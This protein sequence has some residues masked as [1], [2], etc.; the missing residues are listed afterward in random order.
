MSKFDNFRYT[1]WV[2]RLNRIAQIALC[3]VLWLALN[4]IA[5]IQFLRVDISRDHKYSL[6][7]ETLKYIEKIDKPVQI[8][9]CTASEQP[10]SEVAGILEDISNLLREYEY[11]GRI[12]G[13]KKIDVQFINIYRDHSQAQ[14][15]VDK[16]RVDPTKEYAI[17]VACGDNYQEILLTELY[18]DGEASEFRGEEV[19]TS[20]ILN[21]S[22]PEKRKVY[23][24]T[25]HGEMDMNDVSPD[26]GLS[27]AAQSLRQSNLELA[28]LDLT[29]TPEVPDDADL[30]IIAA[31]KTIIVPYEVEKL[32]KYLDNGSG[33]IMAFLHPG[34]VHG[35]D[36]MFWKWGILA[37]DM[38]VVVP[39]DNLSPG[40]GIPIENFGEHPIT[41][42]HR[43]HHL[44]VLLTGNSRPVREDP[45]TAFDE[46]L[47][48]SPLLLTPKASYA[49]RNYLEQPYRIDRQ[50]DLL[51]PISVGMVAERTIDSNLGLNIPSGR[52][53]VFGNAS[54]ITNRAFN[55]SGN[56][57]LFEHAVNWVLGHNEL[58]G[59]PPRKHE[60][61]QLSLTKADLRQ[62]LLLLLA[63]PAGTIACGAII[64]LL[65][66][67]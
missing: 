51:G 2:K 59:I 46:R 9:V 60:Q 40:G 39:E 42:F 30:V 31:P 13:K 57:Y 8:Y 50:Q 29:K 48:I 52:L 64:A 4:Y 22:N 56:R 45:G 47:K 34:L 6:S 63:L 43:T 35:L 53:I 66:R 25:G 28:P 20:S 27:L 3:V 7:M 15:L 44:R 36:D 12:H 5:A 1:R 65:R 18:K 62:L 61:Y 38:L 19:F 11:A 54:F 26:R 23:W 16:Y 58:L 41:D 67:H 55:V 49:E 21:V 10:R 17:V 32:R 33:R 14:M 37:D 24:L